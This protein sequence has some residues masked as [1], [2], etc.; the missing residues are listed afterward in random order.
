MENAGHRGHQQK[1][2]QEEAPNVLS[3]RKASIKLAIIIRK[4]PSGSSGFE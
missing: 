1:R 3:S 4:G 2:T